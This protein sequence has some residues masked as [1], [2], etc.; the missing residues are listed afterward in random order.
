MKAKGI[1][2]V[3]GD[4]SPIAKTVYEKYIKPLALEGKSLKLSIE[5]ITNWLKDEI[6]AE[7]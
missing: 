1:R 2:I 4:C 7:S 3:R 6:K 5:Q